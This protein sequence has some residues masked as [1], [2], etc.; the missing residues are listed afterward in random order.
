MSRRPVDVDPE[1]VYKLAMIQ[2]TNVEIAAFLNCSE[3]TIRVKFAAEL[4]KGREAGKMSLRRKQFEVAQ[5][6]NIAMLIWL[7]KQYLGQ[8]DRTDTTSKGEAIKFVETIL[9][10]QKKPEAGN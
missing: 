9:P 8:T 4:A 1:Q 10:A 3:S 7:G 2:C 5:N 6:G